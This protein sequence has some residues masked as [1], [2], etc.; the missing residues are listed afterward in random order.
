MKSIIKAIFSAFVAILSKIA[1]FFMSIPS[2]LVALFKKIGSIKKPRWFQWSIFPKDG[3]PPTQSLFEIA[4]YLVCLWFCVDLFIDF[5]RIPSANIIINAD[6]YGNTRYITKDSIE[7]LDASDN[8]LHIDHIL[9]Y[10]VADIQIEIPMYSYGSPY[11]HADSRFTGYTYSSKKH[12]RCTTHESKNGNFIS[13]DSVSNINPYWACVFRLAA[14]NS[15]YNGGF[16]PK[17]DY[18][19][20]ED[21][22]KMLNENLNEYNELKEML[23]DSLS[24]DM[25]NFYQFRFSTSYSH[26][27][28]DFKVKDTIWHTWNNDISLFNHIIYDKNNREILKCNEFSAMRAGTEQ[29][30]NQ[31]FCYQQLYKS[32]NY[33]EKMWSDYVDLCDDADIDS[34]EIYQEG[35]NFK[36][37]VPFSFGIINSKFRNYLSACVPSI[38]DRYDISQGWYAFFL[39]TSSIDST[40]LT[41]N[42]GGAT[43]FYP[44]KIEPDE[45][46]SNY[47]KYTDQ[48][49]ILQIRSEGLKFYAKFKEMENIQTIR[50]FGVTALISGLLIIILTFLILGLYRTLKLI[51]DSIF[52]N[53]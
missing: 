35:L 42:F 40:N 19:M 41:I 46:G 31:G 29:I 50:C 11:D 25:V 13:V 15:G 8:K 52:K 20:L 43:D 24:N 32:T 5:N 18:Y 10:Q 36:T 6:K 45:I 34:W 4:I 53:K 33:T 7:Y 1:K 47:I 3:Q 21:T 16:V 28:K 44:M 39:F 37:G 49:K 17:Q 38:F 51:G 30:D 12:L 26:N 22:Y 48:V 14:Y 9:H 27:T 2:W 23:P